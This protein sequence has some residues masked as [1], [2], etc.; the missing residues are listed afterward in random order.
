MF[1]RATL[2]GNLGRDPEVKTLNS[3]DRVCTLRIATSERWRDKTTGEKKERT[4]W[5]QVTIFN[6]NLVRIAEQYLTKGMTV[7]VEGTLQT[8]K[9]H[10]NGDAE[11]DFRYSTEIVMQKFGGQLT[12]LGGGNREG[13]EERYSSQRNDY[14]SGQGASR[15]GG[16]GF[17]DG[18]REGPKESFQADLD[19]EIPF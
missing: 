7:M 10:K 2:I 14:G 17:G 5:H 4:E 11:D 6:E 15:G 19:D 16:G 18:R 8:R 9:W 13:A 1:N 3:G 12:M